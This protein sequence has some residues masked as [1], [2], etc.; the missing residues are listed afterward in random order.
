[1]NQKIWSAILS[2]VLEALINMICKIEFEPSWYTS[3]VWVYEWMAATCKAAAN[4]ALPIRQLPH[5]NS[6]IATCKFM[7]TSSG[8]NI[9]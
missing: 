4:N 2:C 8:I 9:E 5:V 1:M 7:L 6:A 3:S